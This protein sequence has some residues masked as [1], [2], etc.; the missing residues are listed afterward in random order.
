MSNNR[1]KAIVAAVLV[2]TAIVLYGLLHDISALA[3]FQH[4]LFSESAFG[5]TLVRFFSRAHQEFMPYFTRIPFWKLVNN[6][7]VDALWFAS[8]T[9]FMHLLLDNPMNYML[10]IVMAILSEGSQ[11]LFPQLGSFDVRDLL[12]Y[13]LILAVYRLNG[14]MLYGRSSR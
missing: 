2:L 9:I 5:K 3:L 13:A 11:L 10:C 12:L 1:S 6:Y 7:L 8:F 4:P 14:S